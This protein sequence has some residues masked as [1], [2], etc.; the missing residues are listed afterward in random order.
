MKTL[1]T[2]S[3]SLAIALSTGARADP[4]SLEAAKASPRRIAEATC[5]LVGMVRQIA[6]LEQGSPGYQVMSI[7]IEKEIKA[8]DALKAQEIEKVR[9]LTPKLTETEKGELSAYIDGVQLTKVCPAA[10]T[11]K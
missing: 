2:L 8:L 1:R 11:R 10:P 7:E 3:L 5:P 6:K 9:A 4:Q